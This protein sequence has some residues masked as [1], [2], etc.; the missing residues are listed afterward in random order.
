MNDRQRI[1]LVRLDAIGDW[2]LSRNALRALR[3]SPRYAEA[4]FTILG[5]PAWRG[6]AEAFDRDLA[7]EWIWVDNRGDLFR[8]GY[9]NLLPR[10]IWHRRVAR[11]QQRLRADLAA[12]SFDEVLSL[13][14]H[15]D[16]ILDELLTG[17]APSVVGVRC[18]ALTSSMYKRLL[19][20][21]S[22]PFVFLQARALVSQLAGEPCNEPLSLKTGVESH[23]RSILIFTG[24]SHWT[25]R[26]PR[27]RVRVLVQLLLAKTDRLILLTDGTGDTSLR[28][29][30]QSF[31]SHRVEALPAM[32][33]TDFAR[34]IAS[35]G[36]VVTNDTMTLHL[37]AATDTTV[38]AVVNGIEGRDGFWPY[39]TSIGKRVAIVGAE[40]HHK[41]VRFL[42]RL[43][44]SQLAKYRNLAAIQA[45]DVFAE[46]LQLLDTP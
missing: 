1:L 35:V 9:E 41:P 32:P 6:L 14:P 31:Q 34:H 5:N 16:P 24:A 15:R 28:T 22:E 39:P 2:I 36:A 46:L 29:F 4:H 20:P 18:D 27:R 13:Q 23:G 38:V 30:A 7:D 25:K 40:P 3:H 44:T 11:A 26:W 12:R 17:L 43:V 19:D 33:L 8:K 37:A 21:S 10:A 45:D 42:P